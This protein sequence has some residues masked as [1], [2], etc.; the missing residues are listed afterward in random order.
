MTAQTTA[1]D[2][3]QRRNL[4]T[5]LAAFLV[6]TMFWGANLPLTAIL[7]RAFDPFWLTLWRLVLATTALAAVVWA[8]EGRA[9]LRV[10]ISRLRFVLLG[11]SLSAFFIDYNL[12]LR[13][14]NTITAAAVMAGAPIYAV[15]TLWLV[16]RAP[17][18]RGLG[19]ALALTVAGSAI[20]IYGRAGAGGL[21]LE[22]GEPL[23][24]LSIVL[25]T[26]YSILAQRWFPAGTSQL[27]RAYVA[28]LASVVWLFLYWGICR[29]AGAVGPP[30][31]AP[32]SDVIL[33]LVITAV[34]ATA[35]GNYTWNIGVSRLGIAM[36]AL[37]QNAVP[38]FGVLIAMLFGIQS[39]MEQIVGGAVVVA[40]A[41]YMQWRRFRT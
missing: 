13:F 38:V 30:N 35:L 5:G 14:T 2:A 1:L 15:I 41:L 18:E 9:A 34:F 20:A 33:L 19:V 28:S 22:G 11:L 6:T 21:H 25:W 37:W 12:A 23:V 10:G 8:T 3:A 32:G 36:G 17:P 16:T 4:W 27:R 24:M 29:I 39:T 31:I 7:L 40:G 26:L